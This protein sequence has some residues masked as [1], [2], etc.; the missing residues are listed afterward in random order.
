MKK[1]IDARGLDCRQPLLLAKGANAEADE[2]TVIV[3]SE[4]AVENIRRLAGKMS[5]GFSVTKKENSLWEVELT[6]TGATAP[7]AADAPDLE[8]E[9]S[10]G[11]APAGKAGSYV[12]VLSDNRMGRGD[13]TLGE[14]LIRAFMDTLLMIKPLPTTVVCYNAGV[15]LAVQGCGPGGSAAIGKGRGG[16]PG[17]R[18]LPE[19]FRPRRAA[20]G[21]PRLQHVRYPGN[22]G[23]RS[24]VGAPP[25]IRDLPGRIDGPAETAYHSRAEH[26]QLY[27]LRECWLHVTNRCNLSCKHSMFRSSPQEREELSPEDC[28]TLIG[29]YNPD[30]AILKHDDTVL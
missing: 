26:L 13:D 3:D 24:P 12:V 19:A 2:V 9:L 11:V 27:S 25:E 18:H 8:A 30:W 7:G 15:R 21:R 5:C 17:L 22:H 14:V 6:K 28:E 16:H 10:C 29:E 1:T 23:G 4:I 20:W